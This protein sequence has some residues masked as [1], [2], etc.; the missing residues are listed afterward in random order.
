[1]RK[2]VTFLG[3]GGVTKMDKTKLNSLALGGA[4]LQ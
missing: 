3:K 2:T 1:M 4:V